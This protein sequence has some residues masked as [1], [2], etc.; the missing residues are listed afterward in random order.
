MG[1]KPLFGY[2]RNQEIK[3]LQSSLLNA[4]QYSAMQPPADDGLRNGKEMKKSEMQLTEFWKSKNRNK[5][6]KAVHKS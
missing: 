3:Q 2:P 1:G 4:T 5:K 6:E